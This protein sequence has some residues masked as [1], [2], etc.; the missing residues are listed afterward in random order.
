MTK[1]VHDI[2]SVGD[3]HGIFVRRT[4]HR[5]QQGGTTQSDKGF[6]ID[7]VL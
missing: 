6:E 7:V 3:E 2:V 5:I 4:A 1:F